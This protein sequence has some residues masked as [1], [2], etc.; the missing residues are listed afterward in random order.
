MSS[1]PNLITDK[2]YH[3]ESRVADLE[4]SLSDFQLIA[5][6]AKKEAAESLSQVNSVKAQLSLAN[7]QIKKLTE[8]QLQDEVRSRRNNL[9]FLG[10]EEDKNRES[11]II[12]EKKLRR[13]LKE[14]FGLDKVDS[15]VITR[16]HRTGPTNPKYPRVIIANF[17]NFDDKMA[18]WKAR[19]SVTNP[20]IRVQ[21]DYPVEILARRK[22]L[23]PSLHAIRKSN[24]SALESEKL[25][26]A[27]VVDKLF[28]DGRMFSTQNIH[29]Q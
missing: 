2:T 10:I 14:D 9:R 21:E 3:T 27:L 24:E 22:I 1:K 12:S 28:V 5:D 25:D 7:S 19:F 18:V 8:K 23:L 17:A 16:A 13:V 11:Q 4:K 26:V 29:H 15:F 20:A 6:N